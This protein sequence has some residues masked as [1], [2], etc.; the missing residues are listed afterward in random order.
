M[1]NKSWTKKSKIIKFFENISRLP[2]NYLSSVALKCLF[3]LHSYILYGPTEVLKTEFNLEEF[4]SSFV[5]LWKQRFATN[6]YDN[7][8]YIY[9][10]FRTDLK[11][12]IFRNF[13]APTVNT[14]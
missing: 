6:I 7:D 3:S 4:L 11:I 9:N 12:A 5:N 2:I 1:L 10:L 14:S 8:V 13:Y